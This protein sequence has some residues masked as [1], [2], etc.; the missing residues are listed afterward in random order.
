MGEGKTHLEMAVWKPS[1][2][3]LMAVTRSSTFSCGGG[4]DWG[5]IGVP[6]EGGLA[7]GGLRGPY[8]NGHP[9]IVPI[10]NSGDQVMDPGDDLG[11]ERQ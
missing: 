8:L 3:V 10:L 9:K 1:T 11:T 2:L 6:A 5:E 7:E 4:E